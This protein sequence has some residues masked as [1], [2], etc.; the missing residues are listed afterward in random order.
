M[1]RSVAVAAPAKGKRIWLQV[2]KVSL[3]S[4]CTSTCRPALSQ[5]EA[6]RRRDA[7]AAGIL[8][9]SGPIFRDPL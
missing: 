5:G 2:T 4:S 3:A 7:M 6:V 8:V 9:L 1:E